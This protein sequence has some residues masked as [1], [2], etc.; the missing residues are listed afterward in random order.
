M[1]ESCKTMVSCAVCI[2]KEL[3]VDVG[4]HHGWALSPF[5]FAIVMN[6]LTEE[7]R[8]ESTWTLMFANDTVI[9]SDDQI[10]FTVVERWT[11]T[12]KRTGRVAECK[13]GLE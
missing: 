11:F 4:F 2:A 3:K 1:Y 8:L 10:E 7:I 13:K 5:L 6:R 12:L 9:C